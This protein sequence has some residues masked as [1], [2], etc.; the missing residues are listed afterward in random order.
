MSF[1]DGGKETRELVQRGGDL[2]LAYILCVGPGL[3]YVA[4]PMVHF[5]FHR[6]V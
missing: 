5:R 6:A 2:L 4:L 1:V 3:G